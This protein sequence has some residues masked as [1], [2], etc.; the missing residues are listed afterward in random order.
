MHSIGSP[1]VVSSGDAL[2]LDLNRTRVEHRL[3]PLQVDRR[4]TV[5]AFEHAEDMAYEQYFAHVSPDGRSPFD[6]IREAGVSYRFA[7][8][9]IAMA[10]TEPTAS[11]ALFASLPH[12]E[13]MLDPNYR[14]IGIAVARRPDGELLFVEDFSD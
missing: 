4:L 14:R 6:R 13:N 12:R 2:L 7:G 5:A 3:P 11:D 10:P 8:E 1:D 9:N